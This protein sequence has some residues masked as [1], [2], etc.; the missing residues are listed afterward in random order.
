M[1][2]VE[3]LWSRRAGIRGDDGDRSGS[4]RSSKGNPQVREILLDVCYQSDELHLDYPGTE[5]FS[6]LGGHCLLASQRPP[7][8][9][10]DNL[11]Y[12]IAR[13]FPHNDTF[14]Y[15]MISQNLHRL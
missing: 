5:F 2:D 9:K 15:L 7:T 11:D 10:V 14:L 4:R 12:K 3:E 8:F 13:Q 6:I 1:L